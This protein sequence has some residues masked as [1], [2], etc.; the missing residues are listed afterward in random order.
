MTDD[1]SAAQGRARRDLVASLV[2]VVGF[3]VLGTIAAV[4][5]AH[6]LLTVGMFVLAAVAAGRALVVWR[7]RPARR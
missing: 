3:V 1:R 4:L 2:G 6:S 5:G 7:A